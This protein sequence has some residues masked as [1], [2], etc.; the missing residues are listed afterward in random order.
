MSV[1]IWQRDADDYTFTSVVT[2][3]GR[4]KVLLTPHVRTLDGRENARP[5]ILLDLSPDE[6]RGLIGVLDVL[7][8]KPS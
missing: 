5:R 6:V 7:P 8:D 3:Q 4:V 2:A 1:T